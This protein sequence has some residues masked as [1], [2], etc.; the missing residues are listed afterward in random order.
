MELVCVCASNCF[1]LNIGLVIIYD[2]PG[3]VA[4]VYMINIPECC[5]DAKSTLTL[6]AAL[7]IA[8]PAARNDTVTHCNIVGQ[9]LAP[10]EALRSPACFPKMQLLSAR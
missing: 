6:L 8:E 9:G 4:A 5:Y 3:M 10:A 1:Y 7:W 2:F